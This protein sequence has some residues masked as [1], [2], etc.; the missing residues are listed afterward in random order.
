MKRAKFILLSVLMTAALLLVGTVSTILQKKDE[1]I[2]PVPTF[3][4]APVAEVFGKDGIPIDHALQ[5]DPL[6]I[7]SEHIIFS[8]RVLEIFT[9][10]QKETQFGASKINHAMQSVPDGIN[11]YLII[12]PTRIITEDEAYMEYSDDIST[13]ISETYSA[14]P[15]DVI[16]VNVSDP[17]LSHLNEYLFFRTEHTWTSMGAYYA[18]LAYCQASG[19]T[20]PDISKYREYRFTGYV[21][22]LKEMTQTDSLL[23][24][25]DYVAFYMSD[26][27]KNEQTITARLSIDEFVTYDSPAISQARMGTDIYI[28]AYFSH[29]I[30]EGDVT[31][32]KALM[33]VGDEFAKSFA[34]WMIPCYEKIVLVDPRY[35]AGSDAEFMQM[36]ADYQI[37]DF[38]ILEN[39]Q[40]LGESILN[41]RINQL[42]TGSTPA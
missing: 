5:Y 24:F 31:N 7:T 30:I 25:P 29:T 21:G 36:F 28:G 3:I 9:Y 13:A 10:S 23:D 16:G 22:A 35:F 12:A 41:T 2:P 11:K 42:L 17:L 20:P 8:D 1:F 33:I 34:G 27:M 40:N 14:M 18:A 26:G 4:S 37:T 32:G 38:L 6:Q 39:A 19:V 15:S